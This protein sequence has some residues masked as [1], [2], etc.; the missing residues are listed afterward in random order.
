M[1]A[2]HM[3]HGNVSGN[4]SDPEMD[5]TAHEV[6]AFSGIRASV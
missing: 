2:S 3:R 6:T 1:T 5:P 4:R